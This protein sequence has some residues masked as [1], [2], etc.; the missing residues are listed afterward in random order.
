LPSS[1][2]GARL[3][4]GLDAGIGPPGICSHASRA[5]LL[6]ACWSLCA[7]PR[8]DGNTIIWISCCCSVGPRSKRID[9]QGKVHLNGGLRVVL[10]H[11]MV[12]PSHSL[13]CAREMRLLVLE[14][15]LGRW[16]M[17]PSKMWRADVRDMGL[18][19]DVDIVYEDEVC[20]C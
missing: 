12:P 18:F 11:A 13:D 7:T 20:Y 2:G 4:V 16:S 8:I 15:A 1:T 19:L 3:T 9:L 14:Q 10:A 5:Q 17:S 6:V